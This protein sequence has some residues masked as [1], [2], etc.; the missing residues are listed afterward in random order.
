MF[1]NLREVIVKEV[2]GVNMASEVLRMMAVLCS[3]QPE[4][5][6]S[7]FSTPC[8]Q[9]KSGCAPVGQRHSRGICRGRQKILI[10]SVN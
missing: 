4:K 5:P 2:R 10:N 6:R 9:L 7:S 8:L 1:R 3:E